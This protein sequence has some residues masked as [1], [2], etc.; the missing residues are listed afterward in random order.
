MRT[1]LKL[2]ALLAVVIGI[3]VFVYGFEPVFINAG[4][5]RGQEVSWTDGPDTF[6]K[7]SDA[8]L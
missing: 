6:G 2:A 7:Q 3:L 8:K 5:F 4:K 1:L